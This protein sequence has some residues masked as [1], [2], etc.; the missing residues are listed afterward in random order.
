MLVFHSL[1]ID[2]LYLIKDFL[3][4]KKIIYSLNFFL[5]IFLVFFSYF[6]T[7]FLYGDSVFSSIVTPP[8]IFLQPVQ[9]LDE[10]EQPVITDLDD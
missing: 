3:I 8:S 9:L 5:V 7:T 1:F 4:S 10:L 2:F 6:L